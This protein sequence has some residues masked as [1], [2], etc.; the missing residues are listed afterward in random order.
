MFDM[1]FWLRVEGKGQT[2]SIQQLEAH[3][4]KHI[5]YSFDDLAVIP[6]LLQDALIASSETN[7]FHPILI[8]FLLLV[9]DF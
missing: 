7:I 9:L 1:Q 2:A 5:L 6:L 8:T 3:D 4:L